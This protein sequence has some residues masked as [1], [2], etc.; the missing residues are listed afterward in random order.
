MQYGEDKLLVVRGGSLVMDI[1]I[2][3][4]VAALCAAILSGPQ[5]ASAR[6]R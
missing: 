2:W 3:Q 1:A 6:A 5:E 4:G